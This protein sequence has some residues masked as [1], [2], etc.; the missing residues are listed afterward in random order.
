M[1]GEYSL[2]RLTA[3]V[4]K[5]TKT[6][7]EDFSLLLVAHSESARSCL[8]VLVL[9]LSEYRHVSEQYKNRLKHAR[10]CDTYS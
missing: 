2:K 9:T 4:Q 7:K 3:E 6:L 1:K 8:R 5:D 10:M